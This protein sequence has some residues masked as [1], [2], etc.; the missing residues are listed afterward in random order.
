MILR[1]SEIFSHIA[2][3]KSNRWI[4]WNCGHGLH[5][6]RRIRPALDADPSQLCVLHHAIS[7]VQSSSLASWN[8]SMNLAW[9][10]IV[11]CHNTVA[12]VIKNWSP[13]LNPIENQ[14]TIMN[15]RV[16]KLQRK[17]KEELLDLVIE[18]AGERLSSRINHLKQFDQVQANDPWQGSIV[19]RTTFLARDSPEEDIDHETCKIDSTSRF[20]G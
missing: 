8:G 7:A 16:K 11:R 1:P 12:T 3:G 15:R 6:I 20:L 19:L 13:N 18:K 9:Q 4:A 2:A 17:M 14:W 5:L 10:R